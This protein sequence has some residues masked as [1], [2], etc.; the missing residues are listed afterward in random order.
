[1][2]RAKA[3]ARCFFCLS[4]SCLLAVF[5]LHLR[6]LSKLCNTF[7]RPFP[8]LQHPLNI[9]RNTSSPT[10][11]TIWSSQTRWTSDITRTVHVITF[12]RFRTVAS[13]YAVFAVSSIRTLYKYIYKEE[14]LKKKETRK[15]M[16]ATHGFSSPIYETRKYPQL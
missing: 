14:K 11:L 5:S 10:F 16:L 1:M 15:M 6:L 7:L 9:L 3:R 4:V 8:C 12:P 13:S 2:V